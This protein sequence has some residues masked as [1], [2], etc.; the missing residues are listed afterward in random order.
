[1]TPKD[2]YEIWCKRYGHWTPW[3]QLSEDARLAW[4]RLWEAARRDCAYQLAVADEMAN[5]WSNI[6]AAAQ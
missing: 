4:M 3:G 1:M 2:L 5:S 6:K